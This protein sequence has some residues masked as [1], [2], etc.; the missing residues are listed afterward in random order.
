MWPGSDLALGVIQ[1]GATACPSAH[2]T[3]GD[4]CLLRALHAHG[5]TGAAEPPGG[6]LKH[7]SWL[8]GCAVWVSTRPHRPSVLEDHGHV[9]ELRFPNRIKKSS[10]LLP[11][12]D[13]GPRGVARTLSSPLRSLQSA[14]ST[15][16]SPHHPPNCQ[17]SPRLARRRLS[18]CEL[19][20]QLLRRPSRAPPLKA[21]EATA[22][23]TL[24]Q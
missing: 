23:W 16:L 24:S 11:N 21:R 9:F 5:A 8:R 10:P 15:L 6:R 19:L 22:L 17:E 13:R 18:S 14:G 7:R 3:E 4:R 1:T 2:P 12:S 20:T